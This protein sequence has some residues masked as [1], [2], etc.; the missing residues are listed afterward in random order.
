MQI[1]SGYI[2]IIPDF[3]AFQA[4]LGRFP[5]WIPI[6]LKIGDVDAEVLKI[7]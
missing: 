3:Q 5:A 2:Q 1:R 6:T 7:L 4:V